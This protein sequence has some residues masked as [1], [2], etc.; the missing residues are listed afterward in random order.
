MLVLLL[1]GITWLGW[2]H[3]YT[4]EH[5]FQS[6]LISAGATK[7]C[8]LEYLQYFSV[9]AWLFVCFLISEKYI[10]MALLSHPLCAIA[11]DWPLNNVSSIRG[12]DVLLGR[13]PFRRLMLLSMLKHR[14]FTTHTHTQTHANTCTAVKENNCLWKPAALNSTL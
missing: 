7:S 1:L 2:L 14:I 11:K 13:H 8:I 4:D 5:L 3:I 9:F 12:I 10:A 6:S